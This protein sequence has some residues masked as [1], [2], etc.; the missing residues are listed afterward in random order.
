MGKGGDVMDKALPGRDGAA[1]QPH[2][3]LLCYAGTAAAVLYDLAAAM[4]RR[5]P[6]GWQWLPD[7]A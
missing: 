2:T 4:R 5:L 6:S 7:S 3:L 1:A